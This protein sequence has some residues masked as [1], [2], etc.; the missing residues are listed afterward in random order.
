MN[1]PTLTP[2]VVDLIA[3]LARV[4]PC[5]ESVWLIR[6]RANGRHTALSDTDLL[7]FA[8]PAFLAN[9]QGA[10]EPPNNIDVLVVYDGNQFQDPWKEKRGALEYF[11]WERIDAKE[12]RYVGVKFLP[13]AADDSGYEV[14]VAGQSIGDTGQFIE[15]NEKATRVWPGDA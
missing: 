8:T 1:S 11:K 12:A 4:L 14:D 7:V 9:V 6:S 15:L 10:V 3:R 13:D 2:E 5:P